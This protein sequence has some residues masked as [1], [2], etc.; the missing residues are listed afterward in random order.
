MSDKITLS[1]TNLDIA[2]TNGDTIVE[3]LTLRLEPGQILGLVGESGSGKTTTG[4]A[5]LGYSGKGV[6]I[7]EG[8]LTISGMHLAMDE[9]MRQFRGSVIAYVPQNPGRALN[10]ALRI[11]D[12]IRDI[13]KRHRP[14][15]DSEATVRGLLSMVGLPDSREFQRRFSHQLSGGQQQRVCIAAALSCDPDVIVLDEPT[16]GLDVVSQKK[17]LDRLVWLRNE[18]NISM[19]YVTHDL[20]VVAQVADRIAVMYA[21]RIVEEGDAEDVLCRPRH[22]YTRG[23]LASI[24]DHVRPRMLEAMPG[25]SVGVGERPAGC[26]FAPRCNQRTDECEQEVPPLLETE[27]GHAARCIHWGATAPVTFAPPVLG[28][29]FADSVGQDILQVEGLHAVHR[30]RRETIVAA[31]DIS[32]SVARGGCVALVGESG[33][34]KTTIA[35]TIAGLQPLAGGRILLAGSELPGSLRRR[36][37]G[38]RRSIQL[39]FQNPYDALNP[40]HS[41]R[42][43]ISRPARLLRGMNS[44]EADAE[45]D[46]LLDKVRLPSRAARRY[47][48]ELSGGECQRVSVARALAAGPDVMLC[49][50]VTS[51]LD[52]SVQA[53]VL[54]LLNELRLE[55]G[56]AMLFI[57]HDLGVV[58]SVADEILVLKGGH[59]VERGRTS[60]VLGHPTDEYTTTLLAAAPSLSVALDGWGNDESREGPRTSV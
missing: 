34:G 32:F 27:P 30:S 22:P 44:K 8:S 60:D 23:L 12:A 33:S 24:P 45:V 1:A 18:Q 48:G 40:R 50:E 19:V 39:V 55:L 42:D 31:E 21:G 3:D 57:T 28:R 13:L 41:V 52:V 56:V 49:D 47:P 20:A 26:S 38:Q 2:L 51:A 11:G 7:V 15:S 17:I 54:D 6:E 37:V 43:S 14:E 53:A 10:P 16:T 25:I 59:V 9:S 46:R 58:A 35:R 29:R 36:T 4:R 5:L